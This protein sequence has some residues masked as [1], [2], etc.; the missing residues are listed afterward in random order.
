[1]VRE[2]SEETGLS[3]QIGP[4]LYATTFRT[5][6]WRQVVLLSYL[7]TAGQGDVVLSEEHDSYR[8]ASREETHATL[9]PPICTDMDRGGVFAQL[10]DLVD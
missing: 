6:P 9:A 1:M 2:A 4:L 3:V 7:C 8:W 5:H 10:R